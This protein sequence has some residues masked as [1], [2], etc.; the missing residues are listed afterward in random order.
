MF[1][2]S[3]ESRSVRRLLRFLTPIGVSFVQYHSRLHRFIPPTFIV[4]GVGILDYVEI[5]WVGT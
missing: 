2:D 3:Q 4:L 1:L 5:V